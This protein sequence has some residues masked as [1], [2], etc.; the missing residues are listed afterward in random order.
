[1]K[2]IESC[3]GCGPC[4]V[5]VPPAKRVPKECATDT[6]GT[7]RSSYRNEGRM[8]LFQLCRNRSLNQHGNLFV[9]GQSPSLLSP[10]AEESPFQKPFSS[11]EAIHL[12]TLPNVPRRF[13]QTTPMPPGGEISGVGTK[14]LSGTAGGCRGRR[15]N[16][17]GREV[18]FQ[19]S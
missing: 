4:E 8:R 12:P 13:Q 3:D 19:R 5:R 14:N 10:A 16:E 18:P 1:M 7:S 15:W 2:N 6:V 11:A 9:V 17:T